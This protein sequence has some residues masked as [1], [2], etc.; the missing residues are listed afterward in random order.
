LQYNEEVPI[1]KYLGSYTHDY[2]EG[3][4]MGKTYNLLLEYGERDLMQSWAD[5]TNVP[6][7]RAQEILLFW[8][9]LFGVA[10]AIRHVHHL[11]V[12]RVRNVPLRF[13]G[14]GT[15]DTHG[16]HKLIKRSWHADIKPD[17]ILSIRGR[18]KL[19]DF[20]FSRFAP[21]T[22]RRDGSVPTELIRGF[23]DTYG[24]LHVNHYRQHKV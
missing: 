19:A 17:N 21:V 11:E 23:T 2:G 7:V 9:S 10:D 4:N 16:D 6:P 5:E 18:L 12:P 3:K 22:E 13:H 15:P 14:Y 8:K 24:M 1:V 20:G